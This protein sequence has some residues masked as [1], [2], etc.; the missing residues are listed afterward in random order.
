M[1]K[2]YIV[3][4]VLFLMLF[5]FCTYDP[6]PSPETPKFYETLNIPL[7][8]V[9]YG[10]SELVDSLGN[11]LSDTTND[12]IYFKFEGDIDTTT[13][14]KEI[15]IV[16]SRM[17]F[18]FSQSFE[19]L[20]ESA[21]NLNMSYT[22][23]FKLSEA[24]DLPLPAPTD[25]VLDSLPRMTL[26][27]VHKGFKVFDK[28]G[29][30]YF[31]RVDYITIGSGNLTTTITNQLGVA[32]DSVLIDIIDNTGDTVYHAFFERIE[33]GNTVTKGGGNNLAGVR[34]SDSVYFAI[35]AT[36]AGTDGESYTIPAGTDPSASLM[37]ELSVNDVESVTGIPKPFSIAFENALPRSKN[38]IIRAVIAQTATNPSDTNFISLRFD[39]STDINFLCRLSFLNFFDENG[40]VTFSDT[41]HAN[42]S[43]LSSIRIDGDTLRNPDGMSVVDSI[44]VGA[45]FELLPNTDDS[46]VTIK[47]GSGA[48]SIDVN[49]FISDILL[50]EI[51]GFFNLYFDIP[52]MVI[53]NIPEGF[54]FIEFKYAYLVVTI[55]N[56][57]Q[58]QTYLD[59]QLSGY[60]E[61]KVA[62]EVMTA[63]TI[64][65]ATD[66]KPIAESE[67]KV[68]L[69]PIFNILPDSIRVT[70]TAYIPSNDTSRLQVGKSF[71]GKYNVEVPFVVKI[72][73]VT[74]IPV[75]STVLEPVDET[76]R[77]KINSGL[78][79]ASLFYNVSNG[80]PLSGTLQLLFSNYDYF[81]LD[82]LPEHLDS[83]FIWI[84]D[85]LFAET[86]TGLCYIDIDTLIS[87]RLPPA[88]IDE[89]DGSILQ[90]G[91]ES[92]EAPFD[93]TK[94][95][96]L[97]KD[98]THY[99]RP[100]IHLDSTT[101]YVRISEDNK[102]GILSLLSITIDTRNV[103]QEQQEQ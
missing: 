99:I 37:V 95:R 34:I 45:F 50:S 88:L 43:S 54:D 27:D 52:P 79:S 26:F 82:S 94:V 40:Y 69:A 61:G 80:C 68:N 65:K 21:F 13:L 49:F 74:F 64:K 92:Q 67:I 19:E 96:L 41:V 17:S 35:A 22:E 48:G 75:K 100:R 72:R 39:N 5:S 91:V 55:Y 90:P 78:V 70:G 24:L 31:K 76:T 18:S 14:T 51:V 33:A 46:L 30:P 101:S 97:V 71:W 47:V 60:K 38:T 1:R 11:I 15:F 8:N 77:D 16:P 85:S 66:H 93:T 59:M 83:G 36:V 87:L 20:D 56:E 103:I 25:I 44:L 32:I 73:P 10:F 3:I 4:S 9:D 58:T 86:D 53:K 89:V 2:L 23:E 84:G 102:I 6:L 57:I 63:D 12:Y 29:I 98:I 28:Y 7:V 81:P 42:L 62:A